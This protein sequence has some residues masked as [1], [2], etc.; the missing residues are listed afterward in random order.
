MRNDAVR[1][2][3]DPDDIEIDTESGCMTIDPSVVDCWVDEGYFDL[4][5]AEDKKAYEHLCSIR[6]TSIVFMRKA[7]THSNKYMV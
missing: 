7:N 2:E 3:F 4:D 1:I 5:D 6:P